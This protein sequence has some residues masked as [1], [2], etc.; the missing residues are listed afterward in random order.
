[1]EALWAD[2]FVPY[3]RPN[4]AR[5]QYFVLIAATVDELVEKWISGSLKR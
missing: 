3:V 5:I 4:A 2:K 1:M